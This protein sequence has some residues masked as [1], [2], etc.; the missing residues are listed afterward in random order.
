VRAG[1]AALLVALGLLGLGAAAPGARAEP[2][3]EGEQIGRYHLTRIGTGVELAVPRDRSLG[4]AVAAAGAALG[5]LGAGLVAAGRRGAGLAAL[6][7]GLGLVATGTLAAFGSTRVH[8]SR[9]ELVREGLGGRE[10]R[11][12]S[13][14]IAAIEVRP[15]ER[16]AEDLKRVRIRPWDVRLRGRDGAPLPVRF[17]L[18]SESEARALAGV[19]AEALGLPVDG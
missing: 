7:A 5:A 16:S 19:L 3:A 1:R 6:I 9:S 12:P 17:A 10:Q 18:G 13:A 14:A 15:R 8:A 4:L 11:W 2:M